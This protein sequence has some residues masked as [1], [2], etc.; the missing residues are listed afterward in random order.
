VLVTLAYNRFLRSVV[1]SVA[2]ERAS[3][4]SSQM[5]PA[6]VESLLAARPAGWVRDYDELLVR[7][8][9]AGVDELRRS[10]P[11]RWGRYLEATIAHPIGHRIPV[12]RRW[13][14]IGPFEQSGT[15]TTVKQTTRRLGPSLRLVVDLGD[16]DRSLLVL[17]TGQSG[18]PFSPHYRD[19]WP[20]YYQGRAFALAFRAPPGGARL[21][22]SPSGR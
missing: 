1:E 14:D 9:A 8:L 3:L 5:G 18:Q 10:G 11:A 21:S 15:T 22:F 6:F 2:G 16:F 7:S 4:Y 20:A 17:S 19:Q 12:L 13:F